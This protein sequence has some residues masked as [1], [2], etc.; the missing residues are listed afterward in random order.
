MLCRLIVSRPEHG[1]GGGRRSA[2]WHEDPAAADAQSIGSIPRCR[3]SPRAALEAHL[4][5]V[6]GRRNVIAS[7]VGRSGAHDV[8][9][10]IEEILGNDVSR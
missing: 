9:V 2:G 10:R 4:G 6:L 3:N 1:A 5:G 8:S 7:A